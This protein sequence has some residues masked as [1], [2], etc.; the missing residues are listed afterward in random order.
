MN[1]LSDEEAAIDIDADED[2]NQG[3][4]GDGMF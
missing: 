3:C 4:D 1:N 2:T